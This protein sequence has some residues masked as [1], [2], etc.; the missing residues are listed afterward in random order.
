EAQPSVEP[1]ARPSGLDAQTLETIPISH[2]RQASTGIDLDKAR[3]IVAGGRGIGG[4]EPFELLARIADRLGGAVAASRPPCDTGWVEPMI[5]VGLTGKTVA[6]DLYVAVGISGAT[7][8]MTGCTSSRVIVAI[9][10]DPDAPIFRMASYGVIGDWQDIL[11]DFLEAL[12]EAEPG[13]QGGDS[14]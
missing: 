4:P 13:S 1:V 12:N 11:P 10:N 5:Q 8:H 9:N 3:V 2:E 6:P 14:S 7:Q